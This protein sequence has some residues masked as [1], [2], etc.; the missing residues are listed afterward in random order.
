M[1][2]NREVPAFQELLQAVAPVLAPAL[3]AALGPAQLPL[4]SDSEVL[5]LLKVHPWWPHAHFFAPLLCWPHA[6]FRLD[7]G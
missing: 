4:L 7:L 1:L 3:L 5:G 2:E 6:L